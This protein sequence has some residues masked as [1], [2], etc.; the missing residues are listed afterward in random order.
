[1]FIKITTGKLVCSF[2]AYSL[3]PE[4]LSILADELGILARLIEKDYWIMHVLFSLKTQGFQFDVGKNYVAGIKN[5]YHPEY[6]KY[7]LR[8]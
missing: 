8:K 2:V 5:I 1:L 7:S 6:C 3:Y 4:L